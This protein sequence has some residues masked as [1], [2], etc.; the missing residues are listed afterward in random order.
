MLPQKIFENSTANG[1]ILQQLVTKLRC[2]LLILK[3]KRSALYEN[4]RKAYGHN[5]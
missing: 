1:D 3:E 4:M 2:F 5:G